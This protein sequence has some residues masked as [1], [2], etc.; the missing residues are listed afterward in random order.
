[1]NSATFVTVTNL[2]WAL[3]LILTAGLLLSIRMLKVERKRL[4]TPATDQKKPV[5]DWGSSCG[6]EFLT[7]C[8]YIVATEGDILGDLDLRR[9]ATELGKAYWGDR[10][11]DIQKN[12]SFD[13]VWTSELIRWLAEE[14]KARGSTTTG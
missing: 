6:R 13:D 7:I 8:D 9:K 3:L 2:T 11:A 14:A 5:V 4:Q 10:W 12:K 1:M